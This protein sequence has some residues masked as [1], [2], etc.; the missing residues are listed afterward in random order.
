MALISHWT[1]TFRL[2]GIGSGFASV[3]CYPSPA[4]G[5]VNTVPSIRSTGGATSITNIWWVR[6]VD[7]SMRTGPPVDDYV[8]AD[9]NTIA[10][11][12]SETDR[13]TSTAISTTP[14]FNRGLGIIVEVAGSGVWD[15]F[16]TVEFADLNAA[17]VS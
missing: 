13:S 1:E 5:V 15:L 7:V 8:I 11:T 9:G 17:G 3:T 14:F 6:D 4:R 10:L 16:I 2:S 12:A